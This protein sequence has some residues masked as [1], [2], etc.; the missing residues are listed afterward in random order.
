MIWILMENRRKVER[1]GMVKMATRIRR[2]P[3]TE[4]TVSPPLPR[5]GNLANR[6]RGMRKSTS[7]MR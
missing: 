2:V 7:D 6:F 3:S 1:G 4:L 5:A